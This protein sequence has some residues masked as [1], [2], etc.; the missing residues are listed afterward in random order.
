M[1]SESAPGWSFGL[2]IKGTTLVLTTK[3]YISKLCIFDED[4]EINIKN[5]MITKCTEFVH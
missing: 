4:D 2:T 3:Y 5:L 1:A